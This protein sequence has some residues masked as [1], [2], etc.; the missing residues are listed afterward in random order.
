MY[1]YTRICVLL[2][3]MMCRELRRF[4]TSQDSQWEYSTWQILPA[5]YVNQRINASQVW[6]GLVLVIYCYITNY[7][8]TQLNPKSIDCFTQFL[9]VRSLGVTQLSES[10]L[11]SLT[12]L[13]S[14]CQQGLP[15]SEGSC[16]A[17]GSASNKAP[18][19]GCGQ[20]ASGPCTWWLTGLSECP[21]N[22]AAGVPQREWS[23]RE[24]LRGRSQNV[25]YDLAQ[26]RT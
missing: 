17:G 15:S 21:H 3:H 24:R 10:G 18:S 26:E 25:F 9:W 14:S 1:A 2:M 7:P 23:E 4:K 12:R 5:W 19:H 11:G 13:P 8:K 6:E 20:E 22:T 16:G